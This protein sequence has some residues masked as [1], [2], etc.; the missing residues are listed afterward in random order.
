MPSPGP[1]A[2]PALTGPVTTTNSLHGT[3]ADDQVGIDLTGPAGDLPVGPTALT[4][5]NYVV[6]SPNWDNGTI[7]DAGAVTW[8]D[9]TTGLTGPVTTT[10]SLH[11]TTEHEKV[12]RVCFFADAPE[13]VY[14][15]GGVTALTNGGYAL[16]TPIWPRPESPGFDVPN[17]PGAV[18]YGPASGGVT[19]AI[20]SA[21]S[22]IGTP[23]GLLSRPD[24]AV[25]SGN[26]IV[27]PTGQ[28]RVLVMLLDPEDAPGD[29]TAV[30]PERILETRDQPGYTTTDSKFQATGPL[31][32]G[33]ELALDVAGR[34]GIPTNATAA[35]LNITAI[36]PDA[37]GHLTVYPC[38]TTRPNT[39]NV[40]YLPG[41]VTPNAV[42]AKIGTNGHVCIWTLAT[43]DLITDTAGYI[44]QHGATTPIDPERIL[45]TRDQPGY[46]TT[47]NK[48]QATGRLTAGTELAL[49]VAGR[50]GIPTN[51]TAAFLNITAILP[52]A[53]G[54]LT[55][56]PC[57]TT[58]PNTSNVNYLPGDVTPN[59]VLAKIGTNGHVCIWT[60]ATT[61]L[62][63]DTA[64]YIPQHG[65]TT[66]IEP[67]RILET[68][69]QP[70]YTTTDNKFQATGRLTAGTELAL[71]VAGRGGIPTNATAA[72]LNIT[73]ILPDAPG[74]LTVYPCG[75]TRPNTSNVN[76]LPGDVTPNAVLAKIGTNGHV[77]IW[78]LATTD[79]ITDTAG[80][81]AN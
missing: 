79:L 18:T 46:T 25:T 29:V 41:D 5:G 59:A 4:N 65:A 66:P 51:A 47:D 78:T 35:F 57:G 33:T 24:P 38:G 21:N 74:H 81:T 76:Y 48:F 9:G 11:G 39:S 14:G 52:D 17:V 50:G 34:G 43:T 75:T 10:N 61:D 54:H 40:N 70:G 69:D 36:L 13:C 15:E 12:G 31:T 23:P 45:E 73:A 32:A 42:L 16:A 64:G 22:V 28:D 80:Y 56:Y 71:D 20:S 8:A 62:I 77:C 1:T 19:G 27:V 30:T 6:T 60:L 58:R 44:P 68:R 49:D 63:T 55:V 2:P 67:E 7:T 72:F 37:P 53:P 3:T 26:A